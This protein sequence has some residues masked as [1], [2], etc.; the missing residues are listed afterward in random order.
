MKREPGFR[1]V[2]PNNKHGGMRDGYGCPALSP[3][4]LGPVRHGQPG[5]PDA[6]NI[7]NFHQGNKCYAAECDGQPPGPGKAF[8]ENRLSMYLDSEPHRHKMLADGPVKRGEKPLFS[9]WVTAAGEE[10]RLTYVESRQLYC[11]Y[12]ERLAAET[13]EF[14]Q[15]RLWLAD[16]YNLQICG[17]DAFEMTLTEQG[18]EQAYL[19]DRAPFGHERVLAAMLASKWQAPWQKHKTLVF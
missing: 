9:V 13:A 15:L 16:G 8:V 11:A 6:K 2:Y 12:Y 7:E 3:M 1:L 14:K 10:K 19:D 18:I 4:R 17:Y 5:L